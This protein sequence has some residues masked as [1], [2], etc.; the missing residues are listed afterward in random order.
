MDT[1]NILA[2]GDVCGK[3]GLDMLSKRLRGL[4]RELGIDFTVVNGENAAGRGLTPSDA[5]E[6]F[7]A[8]ADVI[9]LGNHAYSKRDI[10]AYLDDN[11]Y[12]LRPLNYSDAAWGRGDGTFETSFGAVRVIPLIGRMGMDYAPDNP[13]ITIRR[14]LEDNPCKFTLIDM[15]AE[16][17][18]EKQAMGYF[19][20][21]KVSAVWGTHTHVQTSDA[22]V[23]PN[24]TGFVTDLGMTGPYNSVIGMDAEQSVNMFL[25]IPKDHYRSASGLC[26]LEGAVFTLDRSGGL[27]VSVEAIQIFE[28]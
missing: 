22:H 3:G 19:L 20:D 2:I 15:H 18:S 4:K 24:G 12:I 11:Q 10:T 28:G 5:D 1:V 23:L 8:G 27:C 16:A 7:A 26:K 17:T 14:V 21:G 25:G 9:T 13:F 6:I